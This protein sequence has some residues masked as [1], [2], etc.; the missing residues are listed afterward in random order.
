MIEAAEKLSKKTEV[1]SKE[2]KSPGIEQR[3][4]FSDSS[5]PDKRNMELPN[6][7]HSTNFSEAYRFSDSECPFE[8]NGIE[9][10]QVKDINNTFENKCQS[11][12]KERMDH[13]PKNPENGK[14]LGEIGESKYIPNDPEAKKQLAERGVD[15]IE[16]K[17]GIPDFKPVSEATVVI[18]NMSEKRY[19]KGGNFEQCDKK[20]AEQWNIEGRENRT[21]WSPRD[22]ANY[23]AENKL[24]WHECN[25][26]KTCE[27]VPQSI[28]RVCTHLGG[29]SECRKKDV[30]NTGGIF[31]A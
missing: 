2:L 19:G 16:Y 13:V 10:P 11:T 17:N 7:E 1:G 9:Q 25:D 21:D 3:E 27:L 18:D 22:V 4:P 12:L 26:M 29:V 6:L 30:V 28:H 15:G 8:K 31:D 24:T 23:R 5:R 20:C 14:Y